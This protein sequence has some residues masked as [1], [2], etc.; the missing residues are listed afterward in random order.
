MK[1]KRQAAPLL[2][3]Q[4]L[5]SKEVLQE[6]WD[7]WCFPKTDSWTLNIIRM[8]QEG[9]EE[10]SLIPVSHSAETQHPLTSTLIPSLLLEL[11]HTIPQLGVR[12][13]TTSLV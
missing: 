5:V 10:N 3:H 13:S 8:A 7:E 11:L 1:R 6:T 2:S 12:A 9:K 4:N